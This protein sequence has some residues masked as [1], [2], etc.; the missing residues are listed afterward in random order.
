[1]LVWDVATG[2][3]R[4]RLEGHAAEVNAVLFT[5]DGH[6]LITAGA[7]RTVRVWDAKLGLEVLVLRQATLPIVGLAL[8][9]DGSVLAAGGLQGGRPGIGAEGKRSGLWIWNARPLNPTPE[10]RQHPL[11]ETA[12][13]WDLGARFSTL[14]EPRND[15]DNGARF[16]SLDQPRA[17]F[18]VSGS[19]DPFSAMAVTPDLSTFVEQ[20]EN[21]PILVY[22]TATGMTRHQLGGLKGPVTAI[23]VSADGQTLVAGH[24]P[25]KRITGGPDPNTGKWVQQEAGKDGPGEVETWRLSSGQVRRTFRGHTLPVS[26]VAVAANGSLVVSTSYQEGLLCLWDPATGATRATIKGTFLAPVFAPDGSRFMAARVAGPKG[27]K[28][29]DT[30]VFDSQTARILTVIPNPPGRFEDHRF[31]PDGRR[32]IWYGAVNPRSYST[33]DPSHVHIIDPDSGK[34]ERVLAEPKGWVLAVAFGPGPGQLT[35]ATGNQAVRVWD[36]ATGAAVGS[37]NHQQTT[38]RRA[39]LSTNGRRLGF[40]ASGGKAQIWEVARLPHLPE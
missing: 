19:H 8:S 2:E 11:L 6:R 25:V 3:E 23:A 21:S 7:D 36:L 13:D 34:V 27:E 16:S 33:F 17:E 35:T 26:H 24:G 30:V 15:K 1:V 12:Q 22:D 4:L 28:T 14:A 10:G 37:Y 9:R 5:P 38:L 32:I 29:H 39:F 20:H 31:T 18:T 40:V